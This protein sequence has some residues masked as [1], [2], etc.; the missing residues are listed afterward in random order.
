MLPV[1]RGVD[2]A[3]EGAKCIHLPNINLIKPDHHV[4]KR[5]RES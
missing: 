5:G 4:L 1:W 2:F 3:R